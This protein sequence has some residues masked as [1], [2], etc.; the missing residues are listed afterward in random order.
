MSLDWGKDLQEGNINTQFQGA[1][2]L[3][4]WISRIRFCWHF[5]H[6]F[7]CSEASVLRV[8]SGWSGKGAE[9]EWEQ[10]LLIPA[11]GRSQP[12][13]HLGKSRLL[14][15][16]KAAPGSS[17]LQTGEQKGSSAGEAQLFKKALIWHI[18][19]TRVVPKSDTPRELLIA[20]LGCPKWEK[21]I[22]PAGVSNTC[23]F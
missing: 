21:K 23:M 1:T 9:K 14:K 2:Q 15:C 11:M 20:M 10:S 5:L 17:S 8:R 6:G 3:L 19:F 7:T 18:P 16:L 13:L 22:G 4:F 12:L